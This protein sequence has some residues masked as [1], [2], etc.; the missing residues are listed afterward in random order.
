LLLTLI[1]AEVFGKFAQF[2]KEEFFLKI[3]A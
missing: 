2:A 1:E 3:G